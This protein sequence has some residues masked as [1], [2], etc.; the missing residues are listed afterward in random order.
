M[1]FDVFLLRTYGEKS[2]MLSS[3]LESGIDLPFSPVMYVTARSF[4]SST[5]IFLRTAQGGLATVALAPFTH[6]LQAK[7]YLATLDEG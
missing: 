7:S 3:Y 4:R 2:H 6:H 5:A 1:R